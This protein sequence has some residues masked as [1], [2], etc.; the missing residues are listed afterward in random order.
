MIFVL[1]IATLMTVITIIVL[2]APLML[3]SPKQKMAGWVLLTVLTVAAMGIY[4]WHGS[5][6][7]PSQPAL[8]EK[9]G[10]RFDKR[11]L[12]KTE[13]DLSRKLAAAPDDAGLMLSL[14]SVQLQNGRIDQAITTLTRAYDMKPDIIDPIRV[15]LGAAHY[16]AALSSALIDGKK[17]QAWEH[18]RKALEIAPGDAPYMGRLLKDMKE[19][20]DEI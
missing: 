2:V 10:P 19:F 8:F 1:S 3:G 7:I 5:P 13:L 20:K 15:K 12:V 16:A 6:A 18:F 17:E 9:S 14:G 11:Q 4:L